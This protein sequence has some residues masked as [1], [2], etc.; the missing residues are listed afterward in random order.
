MILFS[1]L[2]LGLLSSWHCV[3]MCGPLAIAVNHA[4][5]EKSWTGMLIY[6]SGRIIVYALMGILMGALGMATYMLEIQQYFSILLGIV[7]LILIFKQSWLNKI[8]AKYQ[9]SRFMSF[10]KVRLLNKRNFRTSRGK[11][12]AGIANGFLPCGMVYVALAGAVAQPKVELSVAYMI[13]FGLGT[14]PA[15][16]VTNFIPLKWTAKPFYRKWAFAGMLVI[17]CLLFYRALHT[18]NPSSDNHQE[19]EMKSGFSDIPLCS[20][21]N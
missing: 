21:L 2:L 10:I 7:V 19:H 9:K 18:H 12:I 16:M 11:F 15:L 5:G 1:A 17:S 6:H 3:G 4:G 8:T 20:S 14:F 13:I